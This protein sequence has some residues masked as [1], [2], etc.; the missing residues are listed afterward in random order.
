M[1]ESTVGAASVAGVSVVAGISLAGVVLA[2][3]GRLA[4]STASGVAELDSASLAV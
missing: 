4:D 3:L 2:G 1:T